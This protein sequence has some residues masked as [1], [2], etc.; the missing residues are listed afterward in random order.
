VSGESEENIRA[1]F[2]KAIVR[3]FFYVHTFTQKKKLKIDLIHKN[4]APCVL[5]IDEIEAISQRR[6]SAT[7]NMEH[8]IVTQLLSCFDG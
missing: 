2:D 7:K 6:E 4:N 8:R 1:I 3:W 5:F